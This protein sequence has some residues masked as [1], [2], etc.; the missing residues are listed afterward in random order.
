MPAVRKASFLGC[1]SCS[2]QRT[3][4]KQAVLCVV[5]CGA[6]G[7]R[8]GAEQGGSARSRGQRGSGPGRAH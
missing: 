6:D 2:E 1:F 5:R 8:L 4:T 3:A 7:S